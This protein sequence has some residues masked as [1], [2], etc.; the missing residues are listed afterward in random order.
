MRIPPFALLLLGVLLSIWPWPAT[1]W[2]AE[3]PYHDRLLTLLFQAVTVEP[4]AD[5]TQAWAKVDDDLTACSTDKRK[6]LVKQ[7]REIAKADDAAARAAL[8]DLLRGAIR[9]TQRQWQAGGKVIQ[10]LPPDALADRRTPAVVEA[11]LQN[12]KNSYRYQAI[13]ELVEH[14]PEPARLA[15]PASVVDKVVP[16]SYFVVGKLESFLRHMGNAHEEWKVTVFLRQGQE[17]KARRALAESKQADGNHATLLFAPANER[18]RWCEQRLKQQIKP[19]AAGAGEISGNADVRNN[20]TALLCG[21][22]DETIRLAKQQHWEQARSSCGHS[23]RIPNDLTADFNAVLAGAY[24]AA[25]LRRRGD[26][27]AAERR[28]EQTLADARRALYLDRHGDYSHSPVV[29]EDDIQVYMRRLFGWNAEI[30]IVLGLLEQARGHTAAARQAWQAALQEQAGEPG[31]SAAWRQR[32]S[33][34][35]QRLPPG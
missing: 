34:W 18:Q 15:L 35:L 32:L 2:D 12:W 25:E 29:I 14:L 17:D 30:R 16:E 33:A 11:L 28:L 9:L 27:A 4:G 31:L 23:A 19:L 22:F 1:A 3:D 7:A 10:A 8:A 20:W 24:L 5:D 26:A 6:Q 13:L 21:H